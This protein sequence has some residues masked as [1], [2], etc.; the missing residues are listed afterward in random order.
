MAG[1]SCSCKTERK[2]A[3]AEETIKYSSWSMFLL[4]FGISAVPESVE[5]KCRKCGKV[6]DWLSKE[7][8]RTYKY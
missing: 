2:S 1:R 4:L 6:F 3:D 7:E 5:Y 8:L